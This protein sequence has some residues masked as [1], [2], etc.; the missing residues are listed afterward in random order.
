HRSRRYGAALH[1]SPTPPED[2]TWI[3]DARGSTGWSAE[4]VWDCSPALPQRAPQLPEGWARSL[5]N[6]RCREACSR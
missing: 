2:L 6:P 5:Q 1:G 4:G 3:L